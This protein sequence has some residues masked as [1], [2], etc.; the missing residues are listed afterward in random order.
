VDACV[1]HLRVLVSGDGALSG[2]G[3]TVRLD[4]RVSIDNLTNEVMLYF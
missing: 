3:R 2:I 1:G 4:R